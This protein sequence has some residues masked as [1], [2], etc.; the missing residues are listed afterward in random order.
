MGRQMRNTYSPFK[1]IRFTCVSLWM[2]G[3]NPRAIVHVGLVV[4]E[5][6]WVRFSP[7]TCTIR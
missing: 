4:V 3:F 2:S 1:H 5:M 6:A 7:V